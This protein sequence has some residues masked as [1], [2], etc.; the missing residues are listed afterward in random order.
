MPFFL[1]IKLSVLS[2]RTKSLP[3]ITSDCVYRYVAMESLLS[4]LE[5]MHT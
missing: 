2:I 4:S 3:V 1:P 5:L